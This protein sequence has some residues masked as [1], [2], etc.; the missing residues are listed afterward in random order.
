LKQ[1]RLVWLE[2]FYDSQYGKLFI[3]YIF[4]FLLWNAVSLELL[5]R[6]LIVLNIMFAMTFVAYK[7]KAWIEAREK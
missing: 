1:L 6:F 4:G 7:I 2:N 3:G 5:F